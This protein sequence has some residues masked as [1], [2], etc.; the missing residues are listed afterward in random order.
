MKSGSVTI[1]KFH[2]NYR[3]KYW[4]IQPLLNFYREPEIALN[5]LSRNH[6][7][8]DKYPLL[9]VSRVIHEFLVLC[10]MEI[11]TETHN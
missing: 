6:N 8:K 2:S 3:P 11:D 1:E 10:P 5:D 9:K 7:P 4:N